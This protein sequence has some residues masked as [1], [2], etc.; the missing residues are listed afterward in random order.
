MTRCPTTSTPPST[1]R[2]YEFPDNSR[3]R[4]PAVIYWVLAAICL[5]L[6]LVDGDGGVLVNAGMLWAAISSPTVGVFSWTSGWRMHVDEKRGARRRPAGRR[7]PGR[8]RLG[9]AGVARPAQ[10]ADLAGAGLLDRGSAAAAWPGAR[11]RRRRHRSASTSS[12]TTSSRPDQSSRRGCSAAIRRAARHRR[13]AP[14]ARRLSS[15]AASHSS[16]WHRVDRRGDR[17][18]VGG[19]AEQPAGGCRAGR[20]GR[21][22]RPVG[23]RRTPRAGGGGSSGT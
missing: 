20:P 15:V 6:W 22:R 18:R 3:R 1:S 19:G 13:R 8:A 5:V 7:L 11:R 14:T 4:R 16:G 9:P 21:C 2:P 23:R 17:R 10:P 12:R